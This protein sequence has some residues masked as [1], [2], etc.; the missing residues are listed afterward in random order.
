MAKT[1]KSIDPNLTLEQLSRA[2]LD[3]IE[4]DGKSVGTCF[5]YL[6]EL[7]VATS[8]LGAGTLVSALTAEAIDK[9][10]KSR[11]VTRLKSGKPKSQLSIDKTR[12]VLRLALA[13]G[14]Q[15]GLIERSPI[16]AKVE[17]EEPPAK[18]PR[19]PRVVVEEPAPVEAQ[20]T[21]ATVEQ[22]AA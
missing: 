17:R 15:H 11:R 2:Y 4:K 19:K 10:N 20:P 21:D 12:R 1:K 6:M 18:K 22:T 5:S 8:E 9:F 7:K 13:F 16:S 3:H 14:E